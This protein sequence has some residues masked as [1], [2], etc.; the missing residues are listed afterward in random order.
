LRLLLQPSVKVG[1]NFAG[2]HEFVW[3]GGRRTRVAGILF[4]SVR[5]HLLG[6]KS[7]KTVVLRND[8]NGTISF[9]IDGNAV[10]AL[11]HQGR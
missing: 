3:S 2:A 4:A 8:N 5:R 10:G 11:V 6:F 9:A 1:T 7:Q